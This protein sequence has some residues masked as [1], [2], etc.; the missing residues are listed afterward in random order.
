MEPIYKKKKPQLQ[1][2][3]LRDV[4][5]EKLA[6]KVNEYL[7]E[8]D[9]YDEPVISVLFAISSSSEEEWATLYAM[10]VYQPNFEIDPGSEIDEI[11]TAA[12]DAAMKEGK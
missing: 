1:V 3:I 4:N 6:V 5:A 9:E 11:A 7:Q 2:E 8:C 12:R 10:V